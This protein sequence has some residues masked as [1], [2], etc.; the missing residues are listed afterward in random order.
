MSPNPKILF[1]TS[2][3]NET[4]KYAESLACLNPESIAI[5][6][7]DDANYVESLVMTKAKEYGPQLI[8][9]IGSRWGPQVSILTLA[10]LNAQVA[11][12]VHICSDA[13][14]PPWWD[15]LM[16][17][18]TSGAFA[19]QVAI[20]GNKNWPLH[21]V[22]MTA[23][24]PI[25]PAHFNGVKPHA[26]RTISCGYAGNPGS[27]GSFRRQVLSELMFHHAIDMRL[28]VN[29]AN[30]YQPM[31]DYL[32][33]CRISINV[34]YTG[35]QASKQV[36]GRVIEAA[37]AG[38]CLLELAG[39]PTADWFEAGVDFAEYQRPGD[40]IETIQRLSAHPEETEAM[41][42]RL[43]EKVLAEHTPLKFWTR[44]LDKVDHGKT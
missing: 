29:D 5:L 24:T 25:D 42:R 28:R 26:E 6:P 15:L 8:V 16:D 34:S 9:Y 17:Y 22:G 44:V 27:E 18:H 12:T 23:L 38:S 41:A 21:G 35:T 19:L 31:C 3:S 11:P 13:A 14:D 43:R 39:S 32:Q 36:K 10:L 33:N 4:S 40:A 37:L 1:I 20:D 7:Y 30:S 2:S